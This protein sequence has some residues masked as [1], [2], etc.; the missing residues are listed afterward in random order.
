ME[1]KGEMVYTVVWSSSRPCPLPRQAAQH[2][3]TLSEQQDILERHPRS[4]PPW[5]NH[6]DVH[7][8]SVQP[9]ATSGKASFAVASMTADSYLRIRDMDGFCA[10][11]LHPKRKEAIQT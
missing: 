11:L 7:D 4:T 2:V 10:N 9:A 8:P 3:I 1:A 6:V 5:E